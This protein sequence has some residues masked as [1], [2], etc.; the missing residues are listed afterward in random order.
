M[1][2][3]H[4]EFSFNFKAR[5]SSCYLWAIW[6]K[7]DGDVVNSLRYLGEYQGQ[8]IVFAMFLF[9]ENFK[10]VLVGGDQISLLILAMDW[11]FGLDLL[12]L[13]YYKMPSLVI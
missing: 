8:G 7:R 2:N 10:L 9:C 11:C 12:A 1:Q 6:L 13:F 3:G 5:N 4:G